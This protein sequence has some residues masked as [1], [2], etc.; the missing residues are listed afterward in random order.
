VKLFL[1]TAPAVRSVKE[2][3]L[4]EVIVS[5]FVA[6]VITAIYRRYRSVFCLPFFW[7]AVFAF[8]YV[9]MLQIQA[10]DGGSSY[11]YSA[12]AFGLFYVG[13][14]ACDLIPLLRCDFR[15]KKARNGS[16]G[17]IPRVPGS[18]TGRRPIGATN[19]SPGRP[20][21]EAGSKTR[22]QPMGTKIE[23]I[24]PV[25]PLNIG[26]CLSL[27]AALIVTSFLF[28]ENGIP[29][30]A[31]FPA[32]AWVQATSGTVNRLMSVFGP[33]CFAS[34]ALVAWGIHRK[35]GSPGA[36]VM[37]YL[38]LGFGILGQALLASKAAAI[39]I[40]IWFNIVL[41]YMNKRRDFR[42]SVVPLLLV[43]VPI[44]TAIVAVRLTSTQGYW[45]TGSIYQTYYQ[46]LTTTT[47][48]P[49]DFIFKYM[50]RFGPMHGGAIHREVARIGDQLTGRPR[51]PLLSEFMYN[52]LSGESIYNTGLSASLTI[53]GTGYMEWGI[54]G[55]LIYSFLQGLGFGWVHRRLLRQEKVNI[56]ALIFWGA[57]INYLLGV[58]VSGTILVTLE[59][60]LLNIIPPLALLLPFC[61][62]FLLPIA[63]RYGT[64]AQRKTSKVTG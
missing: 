16:P 10:R 57:V 47:A 28:A 38:G 62:F 61:G 19:G 45:E 40:F 11:V 60:A 39:L 49:V 58:S 35:S 8:L 23:L 41:F 17:R 50:H 27:S 32:L 9:G 46:R 59:S 55:M 56:F 48:E 20:S 24:F 22:H 12:A 64:Y 6:A 33:G 36:R 13:L 29:I 4:S 54:A 1:I 2:F 18:K 43:V 15:K 34:L 30:L 5:I 21:Q 3:G 42:K 37:M 53:F 26:L 63:R 44:S 7:A 25:L 31:S 52:L 14:L 51:T